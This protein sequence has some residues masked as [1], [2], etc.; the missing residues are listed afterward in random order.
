MYPT[1]ETERF[2][3][4]PFSGDDTES[5]FKIIKI[6]DEQNHTSQF[7]KIRS[8]EDARK[9][10]DETIK[11]GAWAVVSKE[12][13]ELIGWHY[14]TKIGSADMTKKVVTY[15]W[16]RDE[17]KELCLG[18]ELLGKV[19]H[20]AFF[21]VKTSKVFTNARTNGRF[22][23]PLL[24][25]LEFTKYKSTADGL[26]HFYIS[27]EQ[28]RSEYTEIYNYTPPNKA[29][30]QYSFEKP[31]RRIDSIAY[32]K[33]PTEYLCGQ[34]VIAMLAGVS[35]DEVIEV[36]QND[37]GT[38]TQ[39][40]RDALKWYGLKTATK[41]RLKYTEGAILPECCILSVK[42]PG[43]GHWSLYYESK[44]YDPEFGVLGRLPEQAKL[45]YYWEVLL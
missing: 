6:F 31:I 38:S 41:A 7:A 43:Y 4:R 26:S 28:F 22:A 10:N 37:K 33:Q 20:F 32:V 45:R 15:G 3:L 1:L 13:N 16:I 23:Y 2:I 18:R 27:K 17:Y 34:S 30:S 36:M 24:C 14:L 44:Y 12:N 8:M 21:G 11:N 5:V 25:G 42:L 9:L 29:K 19:L 35:V 39:E 40:L